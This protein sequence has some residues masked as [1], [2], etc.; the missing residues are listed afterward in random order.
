ML[1]GGATGQTLG[2][3][4]CGIR[5]VDADNG[6]PGIGIGRGIGRYFARVA[7][8]HPAAPR[9]LLDAVGSK[10]QSWHDE[11]SGPSSTTE[12]TDDPAS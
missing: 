4:L 1:E 6:Q 2:K 8:G 9:L 5:V 12:R 7:L 11:P 10:K 3:R